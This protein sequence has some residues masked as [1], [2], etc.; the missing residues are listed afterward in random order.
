MIAMDRYF[1]GVRTMEDYLEVRHSDDLSDV[2]DYDQFQELVDE[3]GLSLADDS[4]ATLLDVIDFHT[5][6]TLLSLLSDEDIEAYDAPNGYDGF[7]EDD[8]YEDF[9]EDSFDEESFDGLS[10]DGD[11]ESVK[12]TL[13][14]WDEN[15]DLGL[16]GNMMHFQGYDGREKITV[17]TMIAFVQSWYE[18]Q[19]SEKEWNPS[20]VPDLDIDHRVLKFAK[21][22]TPEEFLRNFLFDNDALISP[23]NCWEMAECLRVAYGT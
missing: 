7:D 9:G 18:A 2:D 21:D 17:D 20:Y 4:L 8:S 13:I 14:G 3:G 15:Y 6:E 5:E 1:E 10:W 23:L 11:C 22:N 19:G 16:E 12:G